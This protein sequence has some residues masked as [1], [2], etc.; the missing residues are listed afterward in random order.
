MRACVC[1]SACVRVSYAT[2]YT[3]LV[4]QLRMQP[5]VNLRLCFY[6]FSTLLVYTSSKVSVYRT[7]Y[8][9]KKKER[10]ET[11]PRQ[12]ET[13]LMINILICAFAN[14]QTVIRTTVL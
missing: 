1:V 9:F 2:I 3:V 13:V 14:Q 8:T 5:I 11:C 4:F 10:K 12:T 6:F 7:L